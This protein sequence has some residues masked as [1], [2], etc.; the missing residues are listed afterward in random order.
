[1]LDKESVAAARD[2]LVAEFGKVDIL[3]N[4]AGGNRKDASTSTEQSFFDLSL[5][6]ARFV[7]ELNFMGTFIPCQVFGKEMAAGDSGV[8]LNVSSMTALC[9]LTNVVAYGSA[10]AAISNFTQWLST[11][12][13]Q[14]HSRNI[15]VNAIAPGFFIGEQNRYLLMNK[16][17]SLT[18][19]GRTIIDQT[20][21]QR[22][23]EPEDL[24]GTVL[25]LVSDA[26]KFV[27]GIV[28]PVDGGYSAFSGV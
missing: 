16:D 22:F 1:V 17:S 26:S 7:L 27:S 12:M 3:I 2:T 18:E 25:W 28:V 11:H 4:G 9:P 10:K 6:A 23:G 14:N 8:I 19:R 21:M 24:L 13:L 20:P 5:D 15:R